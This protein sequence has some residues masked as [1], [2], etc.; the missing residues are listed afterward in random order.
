MYNKW[1]SETFNIESKEQLKS[2]RKAMWM[3]LLL[4]NNLDLVFYPWWTNEEKDL[5]LTL[6]VKADE[7]YETKKIEL[8]QAIKKL[9]EENK[10]KYFQEIGVV[11]Q[12]EDVWL[13]E[14]LCRTF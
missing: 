2:Y 10:T 8:K 14:S 12:D 3:G 5:E 7:D 1:K 13:K 4:Q 11:K 9:S 6:F